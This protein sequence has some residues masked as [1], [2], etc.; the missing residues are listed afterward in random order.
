[1][2]VCRENLYKN[3]NKNFVTVECPKIIKVF[4]LQNLVY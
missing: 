1:M 4:A 3:L 2:E